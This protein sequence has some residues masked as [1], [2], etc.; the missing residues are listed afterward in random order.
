MCIGEEAAMEIAY[1]TEFAVVSIRADGFSTGILA[2]A[3]QRPR[4]VHQHQLLSAGH[5]LAVIVVAVLTTLTF[6]EQV[7]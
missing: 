7:V 3:A 6:A 1:L 5:F 2:R 4:F